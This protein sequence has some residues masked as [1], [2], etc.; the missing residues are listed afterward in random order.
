MMLTV[1]AR[2]RHSSPENVLNRLVPEIKDERL[3]ILMDVFGLRHVSPEGEL[4]PLPLV[5]E[6]FQ[7]VKREAYPEDL[8]DGVLDFLIDFINSV[9]GEGNDESQYEEASESESTPLLLVL[10]TVQ[11]M[12]EASWR[13]LELI[14]D[15]A[16]NIAVIL[17]I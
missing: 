6:S 1:L 8:V 9:V 15:E 13:L 7:F 4:V 17:L 11:M 14:R 5:S 12:D 3:E 10:D 2:R 16:T